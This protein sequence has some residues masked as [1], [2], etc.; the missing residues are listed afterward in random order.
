M[1][2]RLLSRALQVSG[3]VDWTVAGACCSGATEL[4]VVD[5]FSALVPR[6]EVEGDIGVPQMRRVGGWAVCNCWLSVAG[7]QR[8]ER[9]GV[10]FGWAVTEICRGLSA[11]L[12]CPH[13]SGMEWDDRLGGRLQAERS[14]ISPTCWDCCLTASTGVHTPH[15]LATVTH[16]CCVLAVVQIGG[17][18]RL[19]SAALRKLANHASKCGTTIMFINQLRYKAS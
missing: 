10:G 14:H 5:T 16:S 4:I 8:H 12:Q 7:E 15:Y 13:H 6:R 3:V 18:A 1:Q 9:E 2:C 11:H 17:Q 19:M